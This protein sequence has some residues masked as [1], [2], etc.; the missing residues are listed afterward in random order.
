MA[1]RGSGRSNTACWSLCSLPNRDR[2]EGVEQTQRA[3]KAGDLALSVPQQYIDHLAWERS[4]SDHTVRA[5]IS[6]VQSA[7]DFASEHGVQELEDLDT[8][9]LRKW[10]AQMHENNDA[11][12]TVARRVAA[13]RDSLHWGKQTGR[14]SRNP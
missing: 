4:H 11:R 13:Q 2:V 7:L 8:P 14:T 12:S 9:V 10:L 3:V 1:V 6:D 5:Y